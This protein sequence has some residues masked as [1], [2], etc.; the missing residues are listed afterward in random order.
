MQISTVQLSKVKETSKLFR[1]DAEYFQPKYLETEVLIQKHNYSELRE[2][3]SVLTDYHA[4]GS[5]EILRGN[6]ELKTEHDF[7]HM[8]RT[9]DIERD[10]FENDIINISEHAYNFLTKTKVYGGEI[11]INKI[12]NAGRVYL[13]PPVSRPTSLGMNQFMIRA[14]EHINNYFLYCYLSGKYGQNQLSQRI[15]GAVPLSIDKE[16]TRSVFVPLFSKQF[17][18]LI[19]KAVNTHFRLSGTSKNLFK[20]SQGL[21]LSELDLTNWQPKHQLTF[22]KNYSDTQQAGRIDAEY[23]QPKYEE[24]ENAIKNYKGGYSTIGNE[25]DQNKSTF[26]VDDLKVYQY[27]E[28]GSV[29]VTNGE[30]IPNEVLGEDLP[31]NAKRKLNKGDVIVSKV[32]TYRG[33]ITIV[34]EDN[35]V[36]SGAFTIL[37]ENGQINKETLLAFLHSKPLLAWSLKPNTG[38]SYP[39]IVD[40]DIL[41]LPIPLIPTDI[42]KSIQQKVTESFHLRKQS[43]HLLESAKKAVEMAIEQDEETAINWLK[44]EMENVGVTDANGL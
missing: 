3:I 2:L 29:N 11:I 21:L 37:T 32:R 6:V 12:G 22:I 24:I 25:F 43:K 38:T 8:I 13:I 5:Y 27:V 28:I 39:V 31:A 26:D 36:G 14:N 18:E 23:Y 34:E 16:S 41:N 15:T 9:V 1:F 4:N 42:Q 17:Q 40:D 44:S 35:Y 19:A 30:I 33:A 10:D 20:E 7:A